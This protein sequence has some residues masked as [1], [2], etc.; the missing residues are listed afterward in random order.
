ML[1]ILQFN[2][3]LKLSRNPPQNPPWAISGDF[4]NMRVVA[5][6]IW[7]LLKLDFTEFGCLGIDPIRKDSS[8]LDFF[9]EIYARKFGGLG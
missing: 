5:R 3:F 9:C 6:I 1:I 4:L 8:P 7:H 2:D